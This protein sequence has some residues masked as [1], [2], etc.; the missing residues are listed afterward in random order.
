MF[1]IRQIQRR[2]QNINIRLNVEIPSNEFSGLETNNDF[3]LNIDKR[4]KMNIPKRNI[5]LQKVL[6]FTLVYY[7]LYHIVQNSH[8]LCSQS[9]PYKGINHTSL[10]SKETNNKSFMRTCFV[11]LSCFYVKYIWKF[12][13]WS[14]F[15]QSFGIRVIWN[16]DP[17]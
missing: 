4:E 5:Y 9:R 3:G 16:W 8:S 11:C 17:F 10:M 7:L 6:S 15:L 13:T 2:L 14:W 1:N 12:H